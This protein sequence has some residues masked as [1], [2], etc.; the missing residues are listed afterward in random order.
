MSR[1]WY[2]VT[3]LFAVGAAAPAFAYDAS[4]YKA[5]GWSGEYPNGFTMATDVS[6][7]IRASLNSDAPKSV[8][9]LLREGATYH[10]WNKKRV[11]S[12]RLEF[13]SFT[14]IVSHELS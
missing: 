14:K 12:D 6:I 5:T 11:A 4:W 7:N 1:L 8:P 3:F 2:L 13:V 9:C 10:Q